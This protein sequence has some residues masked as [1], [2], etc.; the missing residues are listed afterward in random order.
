MV[1]KQTV[2]VPATGV[3]SSITYLI[4]HFDIIISYWKFRKTIDLLSILVKYINQSLRPVA[5]YHKKVILSI[6][7]L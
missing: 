4:I 5:Y 1:A 2:V 7:K 6:L 3:K